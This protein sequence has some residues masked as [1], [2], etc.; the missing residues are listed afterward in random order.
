MFNFIDGSTISLKEILLFQKQGGSVL[1][2]AH[3]GNLSLATLFLAQQGV[4]VLLDENL[5]GQEE[6]YKP[7]Y[8]RLNQCSIR[9]STVKE[10]GRRLIKI[11]SIHFEKIPPIIKNYLAEDFG[12]IH[13]LSQFHWLALKKFSENF[14]LLSDFL[15]KEK[16]FEIINVLVYEQPELFHTYIDDSPHAFYFI[17]R[18][19]NDLIYEKRTG[20]KKI[21]PMSEVSS[22]AIDYLTQTK[23]SIL[24]D[25]KS[26]VGIIMNSQLLIFLI[27]L[28]ES[29]RTNKSK[30]IHFA[31]RRMMDYLLKDKKTAKAYQ[32]MIQNMFIAVKNVFPNLLPN[33]IDFVLTPSIMLEALVT[34]NENIANKNNELLKKHSYIP[35]ENLR[36]DYTQYDL[37]S[38]DLNLYFP[39]SAAEITPAEFNQYQ[40]L[41][42]VHKDGTFE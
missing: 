29:L 14:I 19:N 11:N 28:F 16:I 36:T 33:D 15:S 4:R 23:K 40:K 24:N 42:Y 32:T 27:S 12:E 41:P 8:L 10:K 26:P 5:K 21:I 39:E 38:S 35:S 13:R 22:L 18:K 25:E 30:V 7:A 37:I 3:L 31:G 17:E 2:T 9:L 34:T 20:I 1:R 6:W